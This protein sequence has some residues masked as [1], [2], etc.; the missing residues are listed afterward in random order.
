MSDNLKCLKRRVLLTHLLVI[1]FPLS[2]VAR[3]FS[4]SL[5]LPRHSLFFFFN[6]TTWTRANRSV[7]CWSPSPNPAAG[8]T[9]KIPAT[10]NR[11]Q[12]FLRRATL[13]RCLSSG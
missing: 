10:E 1:N 8:R 13:R 7:A 5:S 11:D 4:L 3:S 6:S 12:S 2:L 9:G